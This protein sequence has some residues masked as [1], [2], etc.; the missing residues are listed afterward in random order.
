MINYLN[1]SAACLRAR[2]I[3]KWHT[4]YSGFEGRC[5]AI[6]ILD[7]S[8]IAENCQT[9]AAHMSQD[10]VCLSDYAVVDYMKSTE[11][12]NLQPNRRPGLT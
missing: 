7:G 1:R 9:I 6:N 2:I 5:N 8:S 4:L 3:S 10:A 12:K 11:M